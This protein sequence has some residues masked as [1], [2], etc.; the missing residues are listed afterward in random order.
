VGDSVASLVFSTT[1]LSDNAQPII[2]KPHDAMF[3]CSAP[4]HRFVARRVVSGG[5][6][7]K[8]RLLAYPHP[9]NCLR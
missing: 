1:I 4:A 2:N 9:Q 8:D 5:A 6:F 7:L 3:I